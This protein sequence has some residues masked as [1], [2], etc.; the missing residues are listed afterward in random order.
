MIHS[1]PVTKAPV[2]SIA[3]R[4]KISVDVETSVEGKLVIGDR[5]ILVSFDPYRSERSFKLPK[6]GI[7]N[8]DQVGVIRHAGRGVI[9]STKAIET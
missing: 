6:T 4:E 2:V 3:S 8:R 5:V 9:A 1:F 7:N